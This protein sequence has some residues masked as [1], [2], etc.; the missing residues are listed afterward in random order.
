M[1]YLGDIM[2]K[3]ILF[4][5]FP[6]LLLAYNDSDFDGVADEHDLCPNSTITDIVDKTGCTIEKLTIP[7]QTHFDIVIGA[8]YID[9]K[10]LNSSLLIDY[11]YNNFIIQLQTA[12]YENG[13]M[14]D[15][16]LNLYY[17]FKPITKISMRIGVGTILPTY[18]SKLD[19]NNIDYK[20][21]IF[22]SY[23]DNKTVL[24][25][26]ASYTIIGDDNIDNSIYTIKYQNSQNYYTGLGYYFLSKFYSSIN[27]SNSS[28]IYKNGDDLKNI[29]IYNYLGIDKHWFTSFGYSKGLNKTSTDQIYINFGYYF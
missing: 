11:Y 20:T 18:N 22:I 26:G 5:L 4:Y 7:S 25:G 14:G 29:S 10:T 24:F 17:N 12:N 2:K 13:G 6:V 1:R 8:N 27:Y 16:N 23:K 19:N 28:S 21:S 15:T 9:N 3:I